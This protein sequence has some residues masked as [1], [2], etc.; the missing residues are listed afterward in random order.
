MTYSLIDNA[1]LTAVQRVFGQIQIKNTDTID[2]DLVALENVLQSILFYDELICIDD[3]KPK[4]RDERSNYFDFIRFL[5]KG[6]FDL[7]E[8]ED[9]AKKEASLINPVIRG[10]EFVDQDFKNFLDLLKMNIIC[11]WDLRSSV[12]YLTMKMLGQPDTPEFEKYGKLNSTIFNE[13]SDVSETFG[14]WSDDIQLI[15]SNGVVHKKGEMQKASESKSR[16]FG[17]ST[18][19]LEVFVASINWLAYK[20]IYYSLVSTHFRADTFLHPIRHAFQL[21]WMKKNGIFGYDFSSKLVTS[22]NTTLNTTIGE[23]IDNGRNMS[24]SLDLPLF[25]AWLAT[26]CGDV[27]GTIKAALELKKSQDFVDVRNLLREIK[28]GFDEKGLNSANKGIEKWKKE[29]SKASVNLKSKFGIKT[30]QGIPSSFLFGV[31]NSVAAI[32]QL[33]KFPTFNFNI[34]LPSFVQSNLAKG[35]FNIFKNIT[36]ELA[37]IERLG[38]IRSLL[39]SSYDIDEESEKRIPRIRTEDPDYRNYRSDWK[40]PM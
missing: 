3:Y 4:Y 32:V 15:G 29:L 2:G 31:Y 9:Q 20:S 37:T 18:R 11:T 6:D 21:H 40:I 28:I 23:I 38:S 36:T 1:S 34:P 25:S 10:G 17:G 19:A 12:Y 30:D 22:L 5:N 33:P 27:K 14:Y 26:Q 35:F 13:L 16:G 39:A 7:K 8:I 24:L